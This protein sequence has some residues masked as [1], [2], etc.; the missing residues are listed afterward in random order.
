[1]G[2][3]SM[4]SR[5]ARYPPGTA[6]RERVVSFPL[7]QVA[8]HFAV[9]VRTKDITLGN[10]RKDPRLA[11]R[12][13][14]GLIQREILLLWIA[15]MKVQT[16]EIFTAAAARKCRLVRLKPVNDCLSLGF[17]LLSHL[18]RVASVPGPFV[19]SL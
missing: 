5:Q 11:Q 10:F 3:E 2:R 9:T 4:T 17:D 14:G 8:V 16:Y 6:E 7:V 19:C 15:V 1:M 18:R 13:P 12:S